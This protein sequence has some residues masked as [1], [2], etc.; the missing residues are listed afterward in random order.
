MSD[1]RTRLA[2]LT[3]GGG[4]RGWAQGRGWVLSL[5]VT[6]TCGG[7]TGSSLQPSPVL[8][9]SPPSWRLELHLLLLLGR[10]ED[11]PMAPGSLLVSL[12]PFGLPGL[13]EWAAPQT[14]PS[15]FS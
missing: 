11:G 4:L 8:E 5:V 7:V 15:F 9:M 6:L 3:V 10:V 1:Q 13:G 2:V 12:F 14:L